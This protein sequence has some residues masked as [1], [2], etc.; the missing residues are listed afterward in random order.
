MTD[1]FDHLIVLFVYADIA[2]EFHVSLEKIAFL[3]TATLVMR[4]VGAMLFGLWADRRGPR[5]PLL[6]DVT[7][8]SVAGF[9]CAFAPTFTVLVTL[10]ATSRI[11]S[12][13][14]AGRDSTL[15]YA[16]LAASIVAVLIAV[17]VLSLLGKGARGIEF[18]ERLVIP[19]VEPSGARA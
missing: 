16:Q 13:S 7:F 3:I 1:A 8:Y 4:P 2:G 12:T 5:I 6:V 15:A 14:T 9:P 17:I 19:G 11:R 18:G 10:R